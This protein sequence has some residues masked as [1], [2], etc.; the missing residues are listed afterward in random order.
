[1]DRPRKDLA[2]PH[3]DGA[4]PLTD[5]EMEGLLVPTIGT[6]SELN[7]AEQQ[8]VALGSMWLDARRNRSRFDEALV[9]KLHARMFGLVWRWAGRPRQSGKNLGVPIERIRPDLRDLI[10][11]VMTQRELPDLNRRLLCATFHQRLVRI[12]AFPNGNGRHARLM[13]DLLARQLKIPVPTWGG[14]DLTG[15]SETRRRYIESLRLADNGDFSQLIEFMWTI[16]N[17]DQ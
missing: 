11:D 7:A 14:E 1:M 12:H 13:T 16:S 9:W 5:E 10:Q 15:A 3:A 8:N 4:T 17:T 6:R 2:S